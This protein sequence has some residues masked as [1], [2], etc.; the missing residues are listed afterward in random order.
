M[1]EIINKEV[2]GAEEAVEAFDSEESTEPQV[3]PTETVDK[4]EE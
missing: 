1:S 3:E 4:E 2:E